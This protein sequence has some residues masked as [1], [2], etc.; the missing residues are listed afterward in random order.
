MTARIVLHA[1]R[2]IIGL[3]TLPAIAEHILPKQ[4]IALANTPGQL[5]DR[6]SERAA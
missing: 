3:G 2:R 5:W 1:T 6:V 4:P